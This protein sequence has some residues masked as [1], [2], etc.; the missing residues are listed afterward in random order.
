MPYDRIPLR[1][2]ELDKVVGGEYTGSVFLYTV[3]RGDS[4]SVLATRFGTTV[5]ILAELNQIED[6]KSIVV[7]RT[8]L[9][10]LRG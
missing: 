3:Q 6:L 8:L 2:E 1:E 5:A 4:L 10:P 7:G 9:I